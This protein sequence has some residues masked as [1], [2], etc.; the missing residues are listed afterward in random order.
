MA[1]GRDGSGPTAAREPEDG[2]RSLA[3]ALAQRLRWE[4]EHGIH[5]FPA[6]DTAGTG[7]APTPAIPAPGAPAPALE[8]VSASSAAALN[9]LRAEIGDCDRCPLADGRTKLVFG[10]GSAR[11][12]LVFVGEGPG[13]DEDLSGR[14]FVGAAGQLLDRIIAAIGLGREDVYICNVVKCRPPGNRDPQPEEAAVCGEFLRRQLAIIKPEVIV[15]LGR[16]AAQFLLATDQPIGRLRGRFHEL[17]DAL[18]MP[19]YHPA[20]LLRNAEGKRPVWEDMKQVRDRLGLTS[21]SR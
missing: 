7:L 9:E 21:P 12:R 15:A 4:V 8:P 20:Y 19:T 2:L 11:A 10:E 5:G 18:V 17:G 1:G 6:A 14:P 13:R 16:P 3:D